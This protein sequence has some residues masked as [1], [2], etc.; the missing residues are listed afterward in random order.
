MTVS[1]RRKNRNCRRITPWKGN[2]GGEWEKE[3]GEGVPECPNPEL[4]S[5]S[6]ALNLY[7]NY[8]RIFSNFTGG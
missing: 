7:R 4:A 1:S 6:L 5:L 2:E 3:G 8:Y